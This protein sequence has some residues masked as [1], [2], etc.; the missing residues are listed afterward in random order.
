MTAYK[1]P[2]FNKLLREALDE[3]DKREDLRKFVMEQQG[4]TVAPSEEEALAERAV[5]AL[6]AIS[7][8]LDKM[9]RTQ[10]DLLKMIQRTG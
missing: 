4:E 10:K 7:D 1:N 9:L 5:T 2:N 8:T 6:V 3:Q